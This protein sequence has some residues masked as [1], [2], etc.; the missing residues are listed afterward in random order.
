[1]SPNVFRESWR[2]DPIAICGLIAGIAALIV[3]G[4]QYSIARDTLRVSQ[5]PWIVAEDIKFDYGKAGERARGELKFKNAGLSPAMNAVPRCTLWWTPTVLTADQLEEVSQK[6]L[7]NDD[8]SASIL[9]PGIETSCVAVAKDA[10][11]ATVSEEVRAG[12]LAAYVFALVTYD[13]VFGSKHTTRACGVIDHHKPEAILHCPF[14][15]AVD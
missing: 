6:A 11:H 1:M 4:L 14:F 2:R 15:N 5:R 12:R 3:S 13:D 7:V 10:S 9:G 8:H